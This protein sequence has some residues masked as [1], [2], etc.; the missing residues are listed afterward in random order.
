MLQ[1]NPSLLLVRRFAYGKIIHT[2]NVSGSALH[3][4]S[5]VFMSLPAV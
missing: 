5:A 4:D 2:Q 3:A 1:K